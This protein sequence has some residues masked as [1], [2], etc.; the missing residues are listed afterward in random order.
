MSGTEQMTGGFAGDPQAAFAST[1]AG[2]CCGSPAVR[3]EAPKEA[4]V[5]ASVPCCG[6]SEQAAAEGSCCGASAKTEAV[7]SGAG[8]CG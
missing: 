2:G 7:A 5:T 8:C 6:T 3:T 4:A 1:A